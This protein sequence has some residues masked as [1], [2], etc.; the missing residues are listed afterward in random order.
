M[1]FLC[2]VSIFQPRGHCFVASMSLFCRQAVGETIEPIRAT[3]K[4]RWGSL[5][6]KCDILLICSSPTAMSLCCRSDCQIIC[7]SH[8]PVSLFCRLGV[9]V[10]SPV[11]GEVS[12]FCCLG[13][14]VLSPRRPLF[15]AR[16]RRDTAQK[17]IFKISKMVEN[18]VF[19]H[20]QN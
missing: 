12:L 11:V 10:L 19:G 1:L 7:L 20:F 16:R 17:T 6:K 15:G 9:T 4:T 13:V 5:R 3:V 14:T 18:A 2:S 8:R